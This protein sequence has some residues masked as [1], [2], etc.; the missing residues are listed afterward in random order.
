MTR[1]SKKKARVR[2]R[3][4]QHGVNYSR[5]ARGRGT[6]APARP[7]P[8]TVLVLDGRLFGTDH[9][10]DTLGCV[11]ETT[12][13]RRRCRNPIEYGQ[14]A[15]WDVHGRYRLDWEAEDP[16]SLRHFGSAQRLSDTYLRQRCQLHL[17]IDTPNAV[18]PYTY[19]MGPLLPTPADVG[20]MIY[21]R[22]YPA[23]LKLVAADQT[24]NEPDLAPA[25]DAAHSGDITALLAIAAQHPLPT[26]TDTPD[27]H[28]D[29][30]PIWLSLLVA[31]TDGRLTD[32]QLTRCLTVAAPEL[33]AAHAAAAQHAAHEILRNCAT[34]AR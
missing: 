20:D 29:N 15:R 10:V 26:I 17:D 11:A 2:A 34:S 25:V 28:R 14:Q 3:M 32:E 33:A 31:R 4:A 12:R 1:R 24:G 9:P 7:E 5:A 21:R 6:G 30:A 8:A 22:V 18:T 19:D 27:P 23:L 16:I 13:S